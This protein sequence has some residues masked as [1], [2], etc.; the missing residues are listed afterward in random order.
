MKAKNRTSF[1]DR[2][3]GLVYD[4]DSSVTASIQHEQP[5]VRKAVR[6]ILILQTRKP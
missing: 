4:S 6:F 3:T 2:T 1:G 5:R